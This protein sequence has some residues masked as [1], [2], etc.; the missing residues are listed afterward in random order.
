MQKNRYLRETIER[1]ATTHYVQMKDKRFDFF[2]TISCFQSICDEVAYEIKAS[3]IT[4]L[5]IVVIVQS[6]LPL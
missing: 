6:W 4:R 1:Q 2:E 3:G 5:E